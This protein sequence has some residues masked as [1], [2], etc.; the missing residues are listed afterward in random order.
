ML[1]GWAVVA[2]WVLDERGSQPSQWCRAV[3]KGFF[4]FRL[5]QVRFK[6]PVV[7]LASAGTVH[8]TGAPGG[9]VAK[10]YRPESQVKI[11]IWR[12]LL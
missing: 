1:N 8:Y 7:K 12:S 3:E 6:G 4:D 10:V 9:L 2:H 5:Q 11:G